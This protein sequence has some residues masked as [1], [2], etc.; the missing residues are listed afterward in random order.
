MLR[1]PT[2]RIG[3][4][5]VRSTPDNELLHRIQ[6]G[7]MKAC[8]AAVLIAATIFTCLALESRSQTNDAWAPRKFLS[9]FEHNAEASQLLRNIL[10]KKTYVEA[11]KEITSMKNMR[12]ETARAALLRIA[13]GEI[14]A[15]YV[16]LAA[17]VYVNSLEDRSQAAALLAAS[18][19]G[20][21][22]CGFHAL[23][24]QPLTEALL[25]KAATAITNDSFGLRWNTASFLQMDTN[26][27][28]AARK[29]SLLARAMQATLK[30]RDARDL[31]QEQEA[32]FEDGLPRGEQELWTQAGFLGRT[33]GVTV[34][35]ILEALG[36][37][38]GVVH[39]FAVLAMANA[40]SPARHVP[41]DTLED[42][43]AA[44]KLYATNDPAFFRGDPAVCAE[45]HGVLT[46][47][48]SVTAR[49]AAMTFLT[50]RPQSEDK[51]VLEWV[52][53]NDT[54]KS[55][56]ADPFY[57]RMAGADQSLRGK[58]D[59]AIYPLRFLAEQA[60]KQ[61]EANK[62]DSN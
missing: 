2:K 43:K 21:L 61:I 46:N 30:R 20:V 31:R 12:S 39:D 37:E 28:F 57:F 41:T 59:A 62:Q 9:T 4:T 24:G 48:P 25:A 36:S 55:K 14:G 44:L 52:A 11:C 54:F 18:D 51:A 40:S 29:A 26:T 6:K 1:W 34:Q 32:F 27:A 56:P 16:G 15:Q 35:M 53:A 49:L 5:R 47:S 42:R 38:T 50:W 33:K 22:E 23:R 8:R 13:Y 17:S 10:S 7:N 60:L 19:S 58:R 3:H 45:L